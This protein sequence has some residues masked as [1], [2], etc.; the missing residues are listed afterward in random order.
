MS[1]SAHH[2]EVGTLLAH[3]SIDA[4]SHAGR[5]PFDEGRFDGVC[6]C[7]GVAFEE[8]AESRS[9][10]LD[11]HTPHVFY[12]FDEIDVEVGQLIDIDAGDADGRSEGAA[13]R[14]CSL[15]RFH[16]VGGKINRNDDMADLGGRVFRYDEHICRCFP[17]QVAGED[18]AVGRLP[19][20]SDY[21]E[22][23]L[24]RFRFAQDVFQRVTLAYLRRD[25]ALLAER[26][27]LNARFHFFPHAL[28]EP[29]GIGNHGR[30]RL[31]ALEPFKARDDVQDARCFHRY[32]S[33]KEIEIP[34]YR[35]VG[36]TQIQGGQHVADGESGA[37]CSRFLFFFDD[38]I[39]TCAILVKKQNH[40]KGIHR[41]PRSG[42]IPLATS[43]PFAHILAFLQQT[44]NDNYTLD[45]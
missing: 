42:Y 17:D 13:Q 40:R 43:L 44:G 26:V 35:F 12:L 27:H 30:N 39:H 36:T 6:F 15:E 31:K 16:R 21:D 22:V 45:S 38:G 29:E 4:G 25:L 28:V 32:G 34:Q 18:A 37:V 19:F 14:E 8:I 5:L 7:S 11:H 41:N 2:E 33:R 3:I 1:F 9:A 24:Q 10:V 20:L 23:G